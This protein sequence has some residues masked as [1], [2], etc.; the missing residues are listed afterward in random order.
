MAIQQLDQEIREAEQRGIDYTDRKIA[1]ANAKPKAA[2]DKLQIEL[3]K[4]ISKVEQEAEQKRQKG[5]DE[6]ARAVD[7]KRLAMRRQRKLELDKLD[8]SNKAALKDMQNRA[9][10][11]RR[12]QIRDDQARTQRDITAAT[13]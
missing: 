10:K 5:Q 13:E 7:T 12:K 8:K 11:T 6:A 3:D 4:Q 9:A 2:R 1:D